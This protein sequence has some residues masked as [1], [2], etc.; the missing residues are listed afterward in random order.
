VLGH[1]EAPEHLAYAHPDCRFAA[2]GT[3]RTRGGGD[4]AL[5]FA[6]RGGQQLR[7][8][9]CALGC[10]LSILADDQ[11]FARITADR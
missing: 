6:F 4:D 9:A 1:L 3:P 8:L 11:T 10:E 7:A 5:Q 2:Q